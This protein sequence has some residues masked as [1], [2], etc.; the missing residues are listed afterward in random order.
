VQELSKSQKGRLAIRRFK[1]IADAL[2]S[3]G[4]YKPS[5]SSGK[6]L[7]NALREIS[8]EIYGTMNDDRSIEINGLEY[9]LNR[10]PRGIEDCNR[11]ILTSQE[12]L[13]NTTFEKIEPPKR[14]RISYRMNDRE[15][16]FVITRGISEV[17]DVL[18]HITFLN[19]EA[20]K[21][22]RKMRDNDGNISPLWIELRKYIEEKDQLK[23]KKLDQAIWNL[24]ILLGR[25]YHETRL[26]YESL[27]K[28]RK[29]INSNNGIFRIIYQLGEMIEKGLKSNDEDLLIYFTPIF[30]NMVGNQ[31]IS[32]TWAKT[33]NSRIQKLGLEKR[34]LHIISANMHSVM[35][36]LFGYSATHKKTKEKKKT[37]IYEYITEIKETT[38]SILKYSQKNGLCQC[39][40]ESGANIDFQI[41]DTDKMKNVVFHPDLKINKDIVKNEKPV[42]LVLDYAFGTQ[43]F[44]I[45]EELLNPEL[46]NNAQQNKNIYSISVMGKAGILPGKKGD[47]MLATAHVLEGTPHNYLVN[48]DM[49]ADDFSE[50]VSVYEGPIVTVLGTS[51]QNRDVLEKFQTSSWNAVGLEMEGGH[52]QRAIS[53]AIIRG[54]IPRDVK[55]RYAYY[56]S[57]NPLHSGQTLASG[58]MGDE[59]IRPTYMITKIIIEKILK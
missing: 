10:L 54:H 55:T 48:N 37:D 11:I 45:L 13:E 50:D 8:P 43:A 15:I 12:D 36:T 31:T 24:S 14:R 3:R 39:I 26:T 46:Q 42:I 47:I 38:D 18:T 9:V 22:H 1:V 21:I 53:A 23:G 30:R 49:G 17:Y 6:T 5:G 25:T 32:R 27:E 2:T 41:I 58:S 33:V 59:G 35:N 40:D 29:E 52:F 56:A 28:G 51:L 16:C 4:S 19:I 44:E 20:K 7:E 34:P 57:D